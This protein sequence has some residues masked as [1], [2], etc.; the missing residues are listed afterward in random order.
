MRYTVKYAW[1]TSGVLVHC[2]SH[3]GSVKWHAMNMS[4]AHVCNVHVSA[5]FH[6]A[7]SVLYVNIS[8]RV[9]I[10]LENYRYIIIL[11]GL[12]VLLRS[13]AVSSN[14]PA[15]ILIE[16]TSLIL[17]SICSNKKL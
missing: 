3:G 1:Y 9:G 15:V 13:I 2:T 14:F 10:V 6:H 7:Q 5:L 4:I 16:A 12:P 8:T 11:A 17:Y